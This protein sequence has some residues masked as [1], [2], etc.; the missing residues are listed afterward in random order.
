MKQKKRI[1]VM[2]SGNGSNLQA[3]ID[4]QDSLEGEIVLVLSSYEEAKGLKRARAVGIDGICI[5]SKAFADRSVYEE[6]MLNTLEAYQVDLIV[7]AGYMRI[8]GSTF[9]KT[10]ANRLVNV[11]PALLPSF[12]GPGYYGDRVHQAVLDAGVKVTGATVHFVTEETDAGPIILQECV[13][14]QQKDTI[15]VLQKRVLEVEHRILVEAVQLFCQDRLLVNDNCV[16][17]VEVEE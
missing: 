1:A 13:R 16:E 11:H 6:M 7:L 8:L 5:D 4:H 14:V 3:L 15:S 9:I 2:I 17:I 12:G 10:Y